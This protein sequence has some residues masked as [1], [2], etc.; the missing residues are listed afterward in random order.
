MIKIYP[1]P[2]FNDIQDF[3]IPQKMSHEKVSGKDKKRKEQKGRG[4]STAVSK[5][6]H[7]FRGV[8]KK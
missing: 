3:M 2:E 8:K 7:F 6:S 4:P 1:S 5:K